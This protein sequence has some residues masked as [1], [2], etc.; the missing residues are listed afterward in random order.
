MDNTITFAALVGLAAPPIIAV[1]NRENWS[2]QVKGIVAFLVCLVLAV[3]TA[4]YEQEVDW[5][6][7]R[8]VLPVVF[9]TAISSYH[10]FYKPTGIA[11]SIEK[12]TG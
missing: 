5:H 1:I 8:A 12:K 2:S 9:G 4:W 3:A 7:L 6:N 10:W 11:P